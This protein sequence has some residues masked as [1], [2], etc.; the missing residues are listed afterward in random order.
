MKLICE[1]LDLSD[2]TLKVI[3]ATATRTTNPILEGIKLKAENDELILSATDLELSIEKKIKADVKIEGEVVV[4]GKFF[5]EFIKKLTNEKIEISDNE[6]NNLLKIKYTDSESFIQCMPASEFPKPMEIESPDT[7]EITKQNL[8]DS[9]NRTIFSASVD[10]SRP[11]LKGVLCEIENF[12]LTVVALDGFRIAICSKK[13]K[14]YSNKISF[15]VPS[16]SLSEISKILED[17]DEIVKV[18]V[19]KNIIRFILGTTKITSRL[20]DGEFFD[21]KPFIPKDIKTKITVTKNMLEDSLER[22]N[23]LARMNKNNLVTFDIK[24]KTLIVSSDSDMG[25]I[26]EKITISIEGK[27][28]IIAFNA[29]Y[30]SECLRYIN[31]EYININFNSPISPCTITSTNNDDYLY[32]ILPVKIIG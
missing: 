6:E 28:L 2:A 24:D 14:S 30:F 8:K 10:D 11:I 5:S 32:L 13:I 12:K 25:K 27:D 19:Q 9:I 17:N 26:V 29:R 31:D 21:F 18:E 1:G 23:L 22:A 3:K 15:I 7:F 16:R 4:P 20:L